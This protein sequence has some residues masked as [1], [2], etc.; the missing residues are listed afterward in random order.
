VQVPD[1]CISVEG[2]VDNNGQLHGEG[3][4]LLAWRTLRLSGEWSHGMPY[5]SVCI[6]GASVL[7]GSECVEAMELVTELP[8]ASDYGQS[9]TLIAPGYLWPQPS[10]DFGGRRVVTIRVQGGARSYEVSACRFGGDRAISLRC[11]DQEGGRVGGGKLPPRAAGGVLEDLTYHGSNVYIVQH[12]ASSE[13][14]CVVYFGKVSGCRRAP[15]QRSGMGRTYMTHRG[16]RAVLTGRWWQD[17]FQPGRG[18]ACGYPLLCCEDQSVLIKNATECDICL[19]PYARQEAD[20]RCVVRSAARRSSPKRRAACSVRP[21]SHHTLKPTVHLLGFDGVLVSGLVRQNMDFSTN[22]HLGGGGGA[23]A[24]VALDVTDAGGSRC[25]AKRCRETIA[26]RAHAWCPHLHA[27]R[28]CS[29]SAAGGQVL[30]PP[31]RSLDGFLLLLGR[32]VAEMPARV[33]RAEGCSEGG[34]SLHKEGTTVEAQHGLDPT[35]EV[36]DGSSDEGDEPDEADDDRDSVVTW[37]AG[38]LHNYVPPVRDILCMSSSELAA[39]AHLHHLPSGLG[40]V[41]MRHQLVEHFHP[42]EVG[43]LSGY[44]SEAVPS[45]RP[46]KKSVQ[47][48][49]SIKSATAFAVAHRTR[50]CV[51][52][53]MCREFAQQKVLAT[54]RLDA[55]EVLHSGSEELVDDT[56]GDAP[57]QPCSAEDDDGTGQCLPSSPTDDNAA[58]PSADLHCTD[59]GDAAPAPITVDKCRRCKVSPCLVQDDRCVACDFRVQR[60]NPVRAAQK[61]PP[62]VG[63]ASAVAAAGASTSLGDSDTAPPEA[64]NLRRGCSFNLPV[65]ALTPAM[66][67]DFLYASALARGRRSTPVIPIASDLYAVLRWEHSEAGYRSP[68]GYSLVSMKL[69]QVRCSGEGDDEQTH[70]HMHCTCSEFHNCRSG[71]GGR[72]RAAAAR[73]CTCCL[74]VVA[75][76]AL[77]APDSHLLSTCSLWLLA[78]R[79]PVSDTATWASALAEQGGGSGQPEGSNRTILDCT[80]NVDALLDGP[81]LPEQWE[82]VCRLSWKAASAG[83]EALART[84]GVSAVGLRPLQAVFPRILRPLPIAAPT[85]PCCIDSSGRPLPLQ[86]HI[87]G[88]GQAWVFVG[89]LILNEPSEVWACSATM[90]REAELVCQP[91]DRGWISRARRDGNG[92]DV[93]S[94]GTDWTRA[95]ALFNNGNA[96]FFSVL[97]LDE[98][99]ALIQDGLPGTSA[100]RHVLMRSYRNMADLGVAQGSLP[101]VE[102]VTDKMWDAWF[103]YEVALKEV[104]Y[105]RF[106]K[107]MKC[108]WLPAKTGSDGCAKVAMNLSHEA[109]GAQVDYTPQPEGE[110]LWSQE[111]VMREC[112]RW[113]TARCFAGAG[114]KTVAGSPIPVDLVPP[115]FFS[116]EYASAVLCNTEARKRATRH[117]STVPKAS[118]LLLALAVAD[119]E[120]DVVA[121]RNGSAD[122][123]EQLDSLLQRLQCPKAERSKM[124]S[125]AQKR[126]WLLSVWDSLATG[127]SHCHM[128]VSAKSGTG[129]TVSLCCPHGVVLV[130]KFLFSQETNRDHDDLMR[131]LLLESAVHWFDDSCGLMA[132]RQAL[133]PSE[134]KELYGTNRGCPREWCATPDTTCLQPVEI[135]ELADEH[136]RRKSVLD[137]ALQAEVCDIRAAKGAKRTAHHP[138]LRGAHRW[139]LCL[140]DRLHQ[141]VKKKTHKRLSC[142]QHL[143]SIVATLAHDRTAIM[144][145]L[146]SRLNRRLKTLCTLTPKRAMPFYHRITYWENRKIIEAQIREFQAALV[147]GQKVIEPEP[148]G[149]ALYVC[150]QCERPVGGLG[151]DRC[152]CTRPAVEPAEAAMP[153]PVP[154]AVPVAPAQAT[155]NESVRVRAQRQPVWHEPRCN[156][157][158]C[159][160]P[161]DT[162]AFGDTP[163]PGCGCVTHHHFCAIRWGQE[164]LSSLCCECWQAKGEAAV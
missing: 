146:N 32:D 45:K 74:M 105:K 153:A 61:L 62:A 7:E 137:P 115:M 102:V 124:S 79:V 142:Q 35:V 50:R 43:Q 14:G 120:F 19:G 100:C 64:A 93:L 5:G 135:P 107:C 72:S 98:V 122:Q 29:S 57:C 160:Q 55:L 130:Y 110:P 30:L 99:T 161:E 131:S 148:F 155:Q 134:F 68:G 58:G 85:C 156:Y 133:A 18:A 96:W 154:A 106:C 59:E 76:N 141:S 119:G 150:E 54:D 143:A 47:P 129:G 16:R 60:T 103:V 78:A 91:P 38:S 40:R 80:S 94:M 82:P 1:F 90:H 8:T 41:L 101:G 28:E 65:L 6:N 162:A 83:L 113:S 121:L 97:L 112:L 24:Y 52:G 163:C 126:R 147:P 157:P 42:T 36:G 116:H 2:A 108:G 145:S 22:R 77:A 127:D 17:A 67:D 87:R 46:R 109:A 144:E 3:V 4:G 140:T 71:L 89:E 139:R 73:T 118:L 158:D 95:T 10:A 31:G 15:F 111:R 33:C 70:L 75:A 48:H 56:T 20:H 92:H 63:V 12:L 23:F 123:G 104:P 151:E 44:Y 27:L 13:D 125:H 84:D 11:L 152:E 114:H 53:S 26:S 159:A 37:P 51:G 117:S 39:L 21:T 66:I 88:N 149:I 136:I 49:Q 132:F 138:F 128:F 69:Q 86:H 81:K 9:P 25:Y 164:A 34:D